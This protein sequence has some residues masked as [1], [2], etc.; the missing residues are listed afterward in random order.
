M[1]N[2]VHAD[3]RVE[4]G[5][6]VDHVDRF[7]FWAWSRQAL[8]VPGVLLGWTPM[9]RSKVGGTARK[10]LDEFMRRPQPHRS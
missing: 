9:L 5:L 10:G 3:I 1:V 4:N 6:I 7:S 8:G 2:D